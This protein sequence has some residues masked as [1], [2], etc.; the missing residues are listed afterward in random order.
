MSENIEIFSDIDEH[1]F[2]RQTNRHSAI[3]HHTTS[4]THTHTCTRCICCAFIHSIFLQMFLYTTFSV[5]FYN[6]FTYLT[7]FF[8][9][10][11]QF[12]F[13]AFH[14]CMRTAF[15][16]TTTTRLK[17]A[18]ISTWLRTARTA[19]A[20]MNMRVYV[21][22]SAFSIICLL[23]Q[24]YMLK[25]VCVCKK[26]AALLYWITNCVYFFLLHCLHVLALTTNSACRGLLIIPLSSLLNHPISHL[27][28]FAS[29]WY[30]NLLLLCAY[31]AT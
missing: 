18:T 8:F 11:F 15:H 30:R 14:I 2:F 6:F 13:I 4:P 20:C 27:K 3:C 28:H 16:I 26:I 19:D 25:S 24:T 1:W 22:L 5:A 10:F 9:N 17:R 12:S 7:F 23:S 31:L 21:F 29:F